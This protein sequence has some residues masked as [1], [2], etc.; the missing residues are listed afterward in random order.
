MGP[1]MS[2]IVDWTLEKTPAAACDEPDDETAERDVA[3]AW[4][5]R[6]FLRMRGR[7]SVGSRGR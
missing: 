6:R 2:N 5:S 3:A 1:L 4:F 7:T